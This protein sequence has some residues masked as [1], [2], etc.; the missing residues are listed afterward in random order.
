MSNLENT[1][2]ED[3]LKSLFTKRNLG[4]LAA[5]IVLGLG[6]GYFF[7]HQQDKPKEEKAVA[8]KTMTVGKAGDEGQVNYAGVVRGRYETNMSFQVSG[9]LL[10]RNVKAGDRV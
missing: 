3:R 9:Q 4:I 10:S 2:I 5:V 8:V 6:V 7:G 1:N